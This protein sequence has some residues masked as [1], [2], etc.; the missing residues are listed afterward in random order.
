K[1]ATCFRQAATAGESWALLSLADMTVKGEGVVAD[2]AAALELLEQAREAG[3]EGPALNATAGVYRTAEA[4]VGDKAEAADYF[5][6]AAAIGRAW[7]RGT[8]AGVAGT[9]A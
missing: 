8:V 1:A 7:R 2:P 6:Q 4:P 5:R 3:L 9:G